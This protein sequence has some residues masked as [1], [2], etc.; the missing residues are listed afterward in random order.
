MPGELSLP[1]SS[2]GSCHGLTFLHLSP[3]PEP[4]WEPVSWTGG[5]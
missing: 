4:A 3:A 5:G 1:R 2:L